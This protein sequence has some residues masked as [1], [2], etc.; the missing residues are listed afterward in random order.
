MAVLLSSLLVLSLCA[1]GAARPGT[2]HAYFPLDSSTLAVGADGEVVRVNGSGPELV[3]GTRVLAGTAD[4]AAYAAD[5]RAWL[6]AGRVPEVAEL[7]GTTLVRDALLDLRVLGTGHQVPVAGWAPAWRYVWPRDSA[8]VASAF[9]RTGHLGDARRVIGFL[10]RMQPES[11]LFEA[12]YRPDGTGSP[13]RR[14]RQTDSLGWALWA[15][16]QV[17]VELPEP[18]R[19]SFVEQHRPLLD[20]ST[21]AIQTLLSGPGS[22]PP[23]SADYWETRER[24]TLS[25]A[26][27]LRAGLASA[28]ELYG[29]LG[30]DERAAQVSLAG[31]RL[32]ARIHRIYAPHYPRTAGAGPAS[33]DL[34]VSYLLP[35]FEPETEERAVAVWRSSASRMARP[36]G[37]LAP[38]GSW[39]ADG[40]SWTTST[41]SRAMTAAFVGDREEALHWLRWLDRH[42]TAAGSLPEKVLADGRPASVAPLAWAAAAVVIASDE[43]AGRPV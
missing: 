21:R 33:V 22:M 25:T 32:A 26:A 31:K 16:A 29:L 17:A 11:G 38:G 1:A 4:S 13:D 39:R 41:S 10:Q 36:A 35:P 7:D 18:D 9:A 5:Q 19:R 34:G 23:A 3:P 43:L 2:G 20:R 28:A 30:E 12:R 15:F 8:L 14:S 37:G 27:L 40:V 6:D 42:R 24:R